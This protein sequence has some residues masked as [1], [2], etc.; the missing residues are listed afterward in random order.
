[1]TNNDDDLLLFD[2][3]DD[4]SQIAKRKKSKAAYQKDYYNKNKQRLIEYRSKKYVC[5]VC[6]GKYTKTHA[7]G[8]FH[9]EKHLK[10]VKFQADLSKLSP[11]LVAQLINRLVGQSETGLKDLILA[12]YKHDQTEGS[13]LQESKAQTPKDSAEG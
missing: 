12:I 13:S 7:Q 9:T 4:D 6:G 2:D 10:A 3:T 11:D 5:S 1:M 8:H